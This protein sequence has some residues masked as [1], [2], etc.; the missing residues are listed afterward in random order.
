MRSARY[1]AIL[2]GLIV[3]VGVTQ[4]ASPVFGAVRVEGSVDSI[5]IEARNAPLAEV[6]SA[7]SARTGKSIRVSP[8]P[9]QRVDGRFHGPLPWILARLLA[10]RNYIARHVD[11]AVEIVVLGPAVAS[12]AA[13]AMDQAAPVVA[14]TWPGRRTRNEGVSAA[15]RA[16]PET[17]A[18]AAGGEANRTPDE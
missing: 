12:P 11:G 2:A 8:R 13:T 4:L 16:A 5:T 17:T 6:L 7:L 14:R 10:G 15:A 3:S 18:A 9:D 1:R